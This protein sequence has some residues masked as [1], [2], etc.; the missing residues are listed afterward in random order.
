MKPDTEKGKEEVVEKKRARPRKK[1]LHD[2]FAETEPGARVE[3][4]HR[5]TGGAWWRYTRTCDGYERDAV[6]GF[7]P[8]PEN[9]HVQEEDFDKYEWR[10]K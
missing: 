10:E 1:T 3:L 2:V 4:L 7:D 6:P 8:G 5:E 9:K